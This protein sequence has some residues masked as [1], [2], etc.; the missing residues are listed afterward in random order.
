MKNEEL[1]QGSLLA[2]INLA[3][4]TSLNLIGLFSVFSGLV[5]Y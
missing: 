3:I 5:C 1:F 2:F 4:T